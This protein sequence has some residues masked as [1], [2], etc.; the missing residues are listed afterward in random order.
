MASI[1][2]NASAVTAS[3]LPRLPRVPIPSAASTATT[4]RP[5]SELIPNRFAAA[6]PAK[7]PL[8][9]ACAG[10]AEPRRTTKKPTTP[11]TM[12]TT[13]A[14]VQAL[15]MNPE[16]MPLSLPLAQAGGQ[17]EQEYQGHDEEAHRVAL[18]ARPPVIAV[19][20]EQH[21]RPRDSDSDDPGDEQR[22]SRSRCQAQR[23]GGGT[24]K[25]RGREDRADGQRR[26]SDRH[27]EGC[28]EQ[29]GDQAH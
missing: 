22:D 10:N 19:V 23:D 5:T 24:H 21:T 17:V 4:A 28:H 26:Q 2:T 11:A 25:Q 14:I 27:C 7:A 20:R 12:A 8:G 18:P 3:C 9:I 13:V 29:E 15:I 6:A 1:I 16:N